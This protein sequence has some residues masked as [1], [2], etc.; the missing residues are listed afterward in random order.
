MN[1]LE[2]IAA[3]RR[4]Q[5]DELEF[6]AEHDSDHKDGELALAACYY[7]FP[8]RH[9]IDD[10]GIKL[11][12]SPEFFFPESW[13]SIWAARNGDSHVR[14]LTKAGALIAAEIDRIMRKTACASE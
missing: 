2:M 13:D 3:E 11:E 6:D 10:Y 4:R 14:R 12:I 9:I 5:V 7:A 1:G 8:E